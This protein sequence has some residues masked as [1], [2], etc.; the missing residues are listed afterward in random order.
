VTTGD[1]FALGV[2]QGLTEFLP[3]SSTGH[4]VLA[5]ELRGLEEG[6]VTFEVM[7]HAASLVA[8]LVFLRREILALFTTRRRLIPWLAIGTVPA[9][10]AYL[11]AKRPIEGMFGSPLGVGFGLLI[12]A[13][14]LLVCERVARDA[15]SLD[16]VTW[17]DALVVG[18]AQ[19]V[20]LVPG[21]SRSGMT[22]GTSLA[23]GLERG[24]AVTFGFLLGA[25]AIG[26][27]SLVKAKEIL[28]LGAESPG[29]LVAGFVGSLVASYA[30]LVVVADLVRRKRLVWFVIYCY[31]VGAAVVLAKLTRLW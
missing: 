22:I 16:E 27:A 29:P 26:G 18:V 28:K 15:R 8:L 11:V 19:A 20:A 10:L 24:A 30:A 4:L 2:L 17:V 31:V 7:L 13:T 12:T 9:A 21:I 1:G 14:V 23:R 5:R 25:A 3:V 6:V